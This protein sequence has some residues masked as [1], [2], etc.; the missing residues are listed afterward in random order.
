LE[1]NRPP[2]LLGGVI[3]KFIGLSRISLQDAKLARL[4]RLSN[5]RKASRQY[6]AA[7]G[8]I[9]SEIAA[10]NREIGLIEQLLERIVQ[11]PAPIAQP[12]LKVLREAKEA[13]QDC[14]DKPAGSRNQKT[15]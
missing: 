7:L 12:E 1:E 13:L 2:A 15:A 3:D 8:E 9:R 5:I 10:T 11:F 6:G 14:I 4:S